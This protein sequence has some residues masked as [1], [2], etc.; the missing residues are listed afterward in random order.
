MNKINNVISSIDE[1]D[2]S[3][4]HIRIFLTMLY[5]SLKVSTG[6]DSLIVAGR[7]AHSTL[8]LI[9]IRVPVAILP[10]SRMNNGN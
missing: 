2:I 5:L 9:G 8:V 4:L 6:G 3:D 1:A 7:M 10:G